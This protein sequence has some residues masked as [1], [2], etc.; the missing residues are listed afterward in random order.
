MRE[1]LA[2]EVYMNT[3]ITTDSLTRKICGNKEVVKRNLDLCG[4]PEGLVF[5]AFW[6]PNGA[7]KFTATA[8]MVLGLVEATRAI[9]PYLTGNQSRSKTDWRFKNTGS[10]ISHA[11]SPPSLVRSVKTENYLYPQKKRRA[12][13]ITDEVLQVIVRMEKQRAKIASLARNETPAPCPAWHFKLLLLGRPTNGLGR[14]G[15]HEM[16]ELISARTLR[17]QSLFWRFGHLLG[18][19]DQLALMWNY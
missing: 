8:K 11:A 19:I 7:G 2:E 9:L 3:V 6:G 18:E 5:I 1:A 15:I 10:L 14:A 17:N 13:Q 16:R 12:S 4:V